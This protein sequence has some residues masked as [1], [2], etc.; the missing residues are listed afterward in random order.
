[1]NELI[2]TGPSIAK[3]KSRQDYATPPDFL[4]AVERRFGRITHDLAAHSGNNVVPAYYGPGSAIG[5][6][7]LEQQWGALEGTLWLNPPFGN[8][9]PWAAKCC[10]IRERSGWTLLLSPASVST[11]W[12]A[13]HCE[14]QALVI[15]LRPRIVFVGEKNGYPSDLMLCAFG[16][17]VSGFQSWRWDT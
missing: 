10:S 17:R 6:D 11:E 5:E 4:A 13:L 7:S 16:H 12:F 8:I 14:G 9:A 2:R 1:M 15:P 3:G